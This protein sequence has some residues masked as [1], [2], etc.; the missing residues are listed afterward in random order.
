MRKNIKRLFA[1]A[2]TVVLMCAL[3]PA[4]FAADDATWNNTGSITIPV[5]VKAS[6]VNCNP[7]ERAT[8]LN[9]T[10]ELFDESGSVVQSVVLAAANGSMSS[11]ESN[12]CVY[13]GAFTLNYDRVGTHNYT[14]RQTVTEQGKDAYC[15]TY[16]A[17]QYALTVTV[18]NGTTCL[19]PVMQMF[20][21][22]AA[23]DDNADGNADGN[24]SGEVVPPTQQKY[25]TAAFENV[26]GT[27]VTLV[28]KWSGMPYNIPNITFT[29]SRDGYPDTDYS[30]TSDDRYVGIS[31]FVLW[32]R[33]LSL[34]YDYKF[35]GK[36]ALGF[37]VKEKIVP[38]GYNA[39]PLD[40]FVSEDGRDVSLGVQNSYILIQTG[41]LNWP[42]YVLCA[43]GAVL[44]AA[45][46]MLCRRRENNA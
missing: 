1:L 27:N 16:D 32:Q 41:Q 38:D 39:G 10:V 22:S 3:A 26:Y 46:V 42:I 25:D 34:P 7:L 43:V 36:D 20:R 8:T 12:T 30:L 11:A 33:T 4:A 44:V 17:T 14:V 13:S 29:L 37:S 5:V 40:T 24:M 2:L 45:G 31:G 19:E 23:A 15:R 21:I 28:K 18:L 35:V 9:Y 6:N